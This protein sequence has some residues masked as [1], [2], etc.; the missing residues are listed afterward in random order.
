MAALR[1]RQPPGWRA[2]VMARGCVDAEPA[3]PERDEVEIGLEDLRLG[4]VSLHL[5]RG[6]LLAELAIETH[7][8]SIDHIGMHVADE[9][10]R[11]GAGS[12]HAA[13]NESVLQRTNHADDIDAVVLVEPMIFDRNEGL[14][15]VA[16][17][18]DSGT[19]VRTSRPISPINDPSLPYTS[20]DWGMST[21]RQGSPVDACWAAG[22]RSG[23]ARLGRYPRAGPSRLAPSIPCR[24]PGCLARRRRGAGRTAG[25]ATRPQHE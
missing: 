10:L 2:E 14:G 16:G 11:D 17:S 8:S 12:A 25:P 20:V 13:A 24:L 3:V 19:L 21:M 6:V 18:E 1:E 9:L 23:T 15:D 5:A 4:V 22:R 7:V